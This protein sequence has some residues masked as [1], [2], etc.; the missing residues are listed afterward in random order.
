MPFFPFFS[1]EIIWVICI[2]FTVAIKDPKMSL[3]NLHL[4][5]EKRTIYFE[6]FVQKE[7]TAK[8]IPNTFYYKYQKLVLQKYILILGKPGPKHFLYVNIELFQS[9]KNKLSSKQ[10][11][12]KMKTVRFWQFSTNI[13]TLQTILLMAQIQNLKIRQHQLIRDFVIPP[14]L[15][16]V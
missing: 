6:F 1:R 13:K 2:I 10:L 5:A 11:G 15:K 14:G 4:P 9:L 16:T 3:S 12:G 7:K 8:Q